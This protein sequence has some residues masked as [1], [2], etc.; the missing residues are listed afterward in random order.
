M[1]TGIYKIESNLCP[2]RVYIG[3]AADLD[4]RWYQHQ[5]TLKRGSHANKKLQNHYN[6]YGKDDLMFSVI[7]NC[8]KNDLVSREQFYI[9]TITPS[10]NILPIAGS[11]LG[12]KCSD[13]T[14]KKISESNKGIRHFGRLV[15]EETRM[16]IRLS[17]KG[18]KMIPEQVEKMKKAITGLKRTEETKI[19]MRLSNSRHMKGKHHSEEAKKKISEA[20]SGEKNPNYK[21]PLSKERKES[22]SLA[23]KG[24]KIWVGRKHSKESILKMKESRRL[25][26]LKRKQNVI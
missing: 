25:R 5:W 7:E 17:R 10:F 16:K 4:N 21:R 12:F 8:D 24:N 23:M 3:S 2:D 14:R 20:N 11:T 1:R 13:E 26:E 22:I 19:K 18:K 9:D 6:K 15:S